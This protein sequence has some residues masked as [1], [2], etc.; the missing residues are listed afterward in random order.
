MGE[1]DEIIERLKECAKKDKAML[2]RGE[3]ALIILN[4]LG[5][6]L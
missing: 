3:T 2:I 6:R 4:A 5:I 1:L